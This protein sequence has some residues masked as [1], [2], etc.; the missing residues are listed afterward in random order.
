MTLNPLLEPNWLTA[1]GPEI[2][3]ALAGI[4][5]ILLDAFGPKLRPAFSALTLIAIVVT[6][7]AELNSIAGTY[8]GGTYVASPMTRIFAFAFL[9]AALLVTMLS[10]EFLERHEVQSGEYYALLLWSTMGM[11]MMAKGTDLLIIILGLELLS[12]CLF[13]L[14]GYLRRMSL[15]TESSLK[16]FLM[17][18]FATGFILY[19][20]ALFYGQ[21]G[22]TNVRD[23]ASWVTAQAQMPPIMTVAFILFMTGVGFKLSLAPFHAW[24]PDVYQ[25]A[26]TPV[27]ALLSTAPKAA[28]FLALVHLLAGIMPAAELALWTRL[29]GVL[30]ILSMILGNLVATAQRD[31]KRMLAYSGIAHVGYMAIAVMV[32]REEAA[33]AIAIYAIVYTLMNIGA[34][35][36]ISLLDKNQNE[37]QTL[38]DI[39]GM[40]F[41]RPFHAVAL[42]IFMLS[43]A[44]IPPTAGFVAKF[45][46]FKVALESGAITIAIIGILTSIVSVFYYLR[47]VYYMYM[48]EADET[49]PSTIAGVFSNGAVALAAIGI[50]FIG[51]VPGPF[52]DAARNAAQALF[53]LR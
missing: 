19:G 33:A 49:T 50:V 38:T 8:F 25:G 18:A 12:I 20:T 42:T 2:V 37:A 3:L 23:I 10:H 41:R 30:A 36:V 17:G 51:I 16:Y 24:A 9:V 44:G 7:F 22:S 52:L 15:S 34:F 14:L 48:R 53:L 1:I 31:L 4:V 29:L 11:F 6:G 47:V 46:V 13:V 26:P 43:L 28:T 21:V 35:G 5:L 40:G 27:A 45:Y 32:L 39:A